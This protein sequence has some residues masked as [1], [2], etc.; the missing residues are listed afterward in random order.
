MNP[1]EREA[2]LKKKKEEAKLK[3]REMMKQK[4]ADAK[5]V[6]QWTLT[7]VVMYFWTSYGRLFMQFIAGFVKE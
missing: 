7:I 6:R 1:E 5:K 3:L 2:Y 4:W